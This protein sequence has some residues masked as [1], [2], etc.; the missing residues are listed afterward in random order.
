[1]FKKYIC[2]GICDLIGTAIEHKIIVQARCSRNISTKFEAEYST[3]TLVAKPAPVLKR[4]NLPCRNGERK[5]TALEELRQV[6]LNV[7]R[8]RG[9]L[10]DEHKKAC[11]SEFQDVSQ[12]FLEFRKDDLVLRLGGIL[13]LVLTQC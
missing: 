3:I 9:P 12:Q 5:Q 1:M 13:R 6:R 7:E 4:A 8:Q 2:V 11:V 10:V